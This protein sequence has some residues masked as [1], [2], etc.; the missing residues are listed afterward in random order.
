[1]KRLSNNE[2]K[3]S[4]D[5]STRNSQ[6]NGLFYQEMFEVMIE[7][8]AV[9]MYVMEDNEF[10]YV[11]AQLCRLVGYSQEEL[12]NGSIATSDLFHR[13]DL[14]VVQENMRKKM[15]DQEVLSRYRVRVYKKNRELIYVEIHSSKA[16]RRGKPFLFGTL[17]DVTAEVAATLRLKENEEKFKSL[18]Y[19]NPDAIFKIDLQGNFIDANP[20]CVEL[21]GY[22][23]DELLGMAF[24]PLI[25][26]E[27]LEASFVYFKEAAQ[28]I[29]NSHD[30]TLIR[31]DGTHRN[32]EI[33]KFPLKHAGETIAVYGIAKDITAK[34]EHQKLMEDLVF[35][36]PLT[37]LPN[38]KL[39]EDRL[40]QVFK[41][42]ESN[43]NTTAVLFLDLDRFKFINDSL[44]HHSGDEFLKIVA[45]RL[46]EN[47][48]TTD[49][50]GRFAGDEFAI[51]LPKSGRSEAIALA[52][53]LNKALSE[54]FEIMG[55]SLSVSASIGI[56]FS[57]GA[58]ETIDSLIKKADTAMYYTKKYGKNN[59]TVYSEELDQKTAY[60]LI[61]E[62]DLKSAI[63]KDELVLHYQP[64]ADLKTG[65]LRAMEALIRWNHPELGLVPPDSFIP[66]SEESGQ[67]VAIGKWVLQTACVQ[68]K[69]WQD[70][71]YPPF[72][73]C[74]NISTIQLQHPNFVQT[75]KDVL[76]ETG[77]DAEWLELEVTESILMEDTKT[78][79]ESLSKLKELGISM[80]ID[81]FGTGY[82][83]LSYLQ[84]FSF[85]RV[86]IDRSFVEDI[87][88]DRNGK[89]ITSTIISLAHK[90]NMSVIAEGIEDETQ[91]NFL[92]EE[93][94][95]SG[96]GYYF[97]RP[98]PAEM[99]DLSALPKKYS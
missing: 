64:I 85:D 79:K 33:T 50:V 22:S 18:F 86:K 52:K 72:K 1:M 59:Y 36:D 35:Y 87:P 51:L 45:L 6:T 44:G 31:K 16:F 62:R 56:A 68:N 12:V 70:Q 9:S 55:H 7:N 11:N 43:E 13:D 76:E 10:S 21:T 89:A 30:L 60:K 91:L 3:I 34:V 25:T 75:V 26:D 19:N 48:R 15:E 99:H 54:P 69:T 17:I 42:G 82:T 53:L 83:S 74:V 71:G 57:K 65:E 14:S 58:D 23:T 2:N 8:A 81:D 84:Q 5:F 4:L 98:L 61:L 39:F 47:V 41:L 29:S 49:T 77:L 63:H 28:G 78:L 94:C 32:I 66:I 97:S 88:K 95:D 38:R 90:L 92:K 93:N 67:I 37:K 20:G 24:A 27:D 80:S 73:L 46:K 96:Q 40:N